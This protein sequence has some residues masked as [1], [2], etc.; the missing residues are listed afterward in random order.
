M[1]R[2]PE[3]LEFLILFINLDS[4]TENGRKCRDAEAVK[5]GTPLTAFF[6]NLYMSEIDSIME[7][8]AGLYI[9]YCDD[10]IIYDKT[11]SGILELKKI[12]LDEISKLHLEVNPKADRIFSPGEFVDFVGYTLAGSRQQLPLSVA[13]YAKSMVR[14]RCRT[15]LNLRR[16][17]HLNAQNAMILMA[18]YNNRITEKLKVHFKNVTETDVLRD[19]DRY[20]ADSVRFA[21]L[22]KCSNTA[23][24][25][26]IKYEEIK[27]SGYKSLVNEYFR[28][29]NAGHL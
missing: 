19:L 15:L 5:M 22:G 18:L 10:I 23:S 9:R 24:K 20:M 11:L 12:F 27:E 25:Y 13:L 14:A 17:H 2:E 8:K 1:P 7:Q 3:L 4:C 21:G 28:F 29:K 6:E 26:R 16:Y